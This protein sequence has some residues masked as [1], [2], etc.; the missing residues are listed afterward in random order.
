MFN[1]KK[2]QS[3]IQEYENTKISNWLLDNKLLNV[4]HMN[5]KDL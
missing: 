5:I 4:E 2:N 3:K 1:E